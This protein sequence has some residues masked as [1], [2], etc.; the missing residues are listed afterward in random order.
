MHKPNCLLVVLTCGVLLLGTASAPAQDW[1]QWRGPNR[2]AKVT[3]FKGPKQWPAEL[4]QKWK[5]EVGDGVAT[6]ALVG[7]KL[8]VF[9]RQEGAEILRCLNAA[10]GRE[11][12]RDQY[13]SLGASGS[14]V[15]FSGPRCSP[16]VSGGRVVT[17]GV[18]G[19]LSCL[20]AE[21]GTVLWRKD[22]F[23]GATPRFQTSASPLVADG[24]CVAQLGGG[25]NGSIVAYD[26][27]TGEEKW[28]W[29][30]DSPAYASPV[31]M[32][33]SGVTYVVAETDKKL[34]L[35][36]LA[37][38]K[39]A[40]E[41]PFPVPGR[42]YNATTPV[43]DG[44]AIIYTGSW[45]G[46]TAVKIGREGDALVAQELWK[47]LDNS[48]QFNSPVLKDGLLYC[49]SV[50]NDFFCIDAKDGRTLWT[51][52]F[53][54]ETAVAA[55]A[56]VGG[57]NTPATH[58]N[59]TSQDSRAGQGNGGRGGRGGSGVGYGSIVDAGAVWLAL[60]PQPQLVV[61]EPSAKEF[62]EVARIKVADTPTYAYPVISG[63]RIF[64]KDQNSVTLWSVD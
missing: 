44:Q 59:A 13:N 45:R 56:T 39:L 54:K 1:P 12:W 11:L 53:S 33:V 46:A 37:D 50:K 42:G 30:G 22:D 9:V 61:F 7:D 3:G 52:P 35:L 47:N 41:T 36:A 27:T 38:G 18:R 58:S 16:T 15:S 43:I 20:D 26:F 29:T 19:I 8:Y 64:I 10:D 55:E 60:T 24:L 32:K 63:N 21:K 4:T 49:I 17:V 28:K 31:L 40:S 6:P 48:V 5:V 62:K 51:V 57:T 25:E 2:D 23:K 34:L 14:A